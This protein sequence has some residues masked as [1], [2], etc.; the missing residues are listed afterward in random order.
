S[1]LIYRDDNNDGIHQAAEPLF[2]G[3]TVQL[4]DSTNAVVATTT[5]DAGGNY[6]FTGLAAGTYS[7]RQPNQ[8]A[9]TLAGKTTAGTISGAGGGTPGTASAVA[10]TPSI[11]SNIVL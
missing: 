9:G 4:L 1:G 3:Q 5:T 10:I 11:I 7:V 6:L 8:P 2:S